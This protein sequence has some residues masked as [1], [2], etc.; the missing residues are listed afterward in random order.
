[1]KWLNEQAKAAPVSTV[2]PSQAW[3]SGFKYRLKM[4]SFHFHSE[5][6]W[7][8]ILINLSKKGLK[9]RC[10]QSNVFTPGNLR[11]VWMFALFPPTSNTSG[12]VLFCCCRASSV[13]FVLY[14]PLWS[15]LLS[16]FV[17]NLWIHSIINKSEPQ[18][19]QPSNQGCSCQSTFWGRQQHKQTR[20]CLKDLLSENP[21][22]SKYGGIV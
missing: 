17:A 1:M 9:T 8:K 7:G 15:Y 3:R 19:L 22:F 2:H 10:F 20:I 14:V 12:G 16:T 4:G 18:H 13:R 11:S 21:V 5:S 6:W